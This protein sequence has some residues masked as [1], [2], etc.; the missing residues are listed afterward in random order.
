MELAASRFR[1]ISCA[2]TIEK[3]VHQ[4]RFELVQYKVLYNQFDGIT[5]V[6]ILNTVR[7]KNTVL[8]SDIHYFLDVIEP[9]RLLLVL[10]EDSITPIQHNQW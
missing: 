3:R 10:N 9:N 6:C 2:I 7:C 5:R 8:I 1:V 4:S